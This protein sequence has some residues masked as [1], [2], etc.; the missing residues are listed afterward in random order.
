MNKNLERKIKEAAKKFSDKKAPSQPE[1][2]FRKGAE[3]LYEFLMNGGMADIYR[4]RLRQDVMAREGTDTVDQWKESLIDELADMLAERDAMNAEIR[5][6][7]RL[8]EK[9]DKNLNPYKESNP[10]YV[11]VKAKEQSISVWRDKLGLSN[12]V[13]PERIK[14]TAKKNDV[15]DSDPMAEYY[16]K[17][18]Q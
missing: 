9:V 7:G 4:E 11:H 1:T 15:D 2:Q 5:E 18:N 3:W 8:I 14:N 6:T 12:T 17:T 13:N 10:L 16:K